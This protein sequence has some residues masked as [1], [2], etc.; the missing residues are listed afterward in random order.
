MT[1]AV[2][3]VWRAVSDRRFKAVIEA[4]FAAGNDAE[5]ALELR[6]AMTRFAKL[7]APDGGA[8]S[9][10]ERAFLLMA[11]E[12][13]LGLALGRATNGG[14]PLGHERAV[15]R[16]LRAEAATFDDNQETT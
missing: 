15:L 10:D 1:G 4:W 3:G 5:L 8:H 2:D 12:A 14:K 9:A 7:V 16:R 13:M 11:R 6:P